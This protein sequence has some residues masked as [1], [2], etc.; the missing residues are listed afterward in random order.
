M[1]ATGES[2]LVNY[3]ETLQGL[4][5]DI[6][7]PRLKVVDKLLE[8]HFGLQGE[9]FDYEWNCIFPESA[10]QKAD[11]IK[12]ERESVS[13]LVD[14]GVISNESGLNELKRSGAI[15]NDAEV[16]STPAQANKDNKPD[17]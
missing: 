6:F 10:S 4:H 2:D 8:A 12:T 7:V 16:G 13:G 9:D 5:K 17:K 11:R 14:S 1:N 3:I 15:S